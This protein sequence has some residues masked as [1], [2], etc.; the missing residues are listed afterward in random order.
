MIFITELGASPRFV[1]APAQ[2]PGPAHQHR[3]SFAEPTHLSPQAD[4]HVASG[5][6]THRFGG[7]AVYCSTYRT[8]LSLLF[9]FDSVSLEYPS[10]KYHPMQ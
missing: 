6:C 5:A 4:Q 8:L 7:V 3:L 10:H 2:L 9:R 1:S